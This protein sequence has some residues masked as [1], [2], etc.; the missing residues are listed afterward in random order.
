MVIRLLFCLALAATAFNVCFAAD[1]TEYDFLVKAVKSTSIDTKSVRAVEGLII[2]DHLMTI[3]LEKGEI[4]YYTPINGKRYGAV[5]LGKAS[6]SFSPNIQTEKTNM[7][8]FYSSNVYQN[9]VRK[10]LFVFGDNSF[11]EVV[12]ENPISLIP[13]HDFSKL[14]GELREF[15]LENEGQEVDTTFSHVILTGADLP[16]LYCSAVDVNKKRIYLIHDPLSEDSYRLSVENAPGTTVPFTNVSSCPATTEAMVVRD[17]GVSAIDVV[18]T[19]Q[20]TISSTIDRSLV[21]WCRDRIDMSILSDSLVWLTLNLDSRMKIDSMREYGT[22]KLE[23]FRA[24]D[25]WSTWIKLP[26]T[27]LKGQKISIDISYHGDVIKRFKDYTVL[28]SSITWYAAHDWGH[29]SFF[30]MTFTYPESMTLVSIGKQTEL[31]ETDLYKSSR[32]VSGVALRNASFHIGLFKER[33]LKTGSQSPTA[34]MLYLTKDQADVVT[35][36]VVQSLEFFAKLY[37][38]LPVTHL[39]ATELPG[40]HG[41]A[42]P[43]LLHLSS[44]A[45]FKDE[46]AK[47]DDFF[48][49]QFT[50]HEAAHQWWGVAVDFANY[51]DQW[52][53]EGFAE[54]SCLLYSQLAA[55]DGAKF[56]RLLDE[57]STEIRDFGKRT[58][59]KNL[60]PPAIAIG[61]R[62]NEGS[63]DGGYNTFVY[64]K[65]AWVLHMLRNM[66][67]D[68]NTM[69][70]TPFMTSMSTFY[71][72]FK[73]KRATTNDF[74]LTIEKLTGVDLRWF[75]DQ[76]VYGN[77]IPTYTVA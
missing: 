64:F 62:V 31:P 40:S 43:G 56:F 37:G 75:F 55:K 28:N 15:L 11:T 23:Y 7:Q 70:E 36:D 47:Y 67:L 41:E 27:M 72:D 10:I 4:V 30:D 13:E 42:F 24:K 22:T 1:S 69:G 29:K 66:M 16:L 8:R 25:G 35:T 57:Y 73:G 60:P 3:V 61:R 46:D 21:M 59:G 39:N 12:E 19:H 33:K 6:V 54:Y 50:S 58:I 45:F 63:R 20:H 77:E 53:S 14:G 38:P 74:R 48:G 9:D 68:L 5:F 2:E 17:D 76:W 51:R 44:A 26:R 18:E 34:T 49:E 71:T 52:L 32:W 65:G